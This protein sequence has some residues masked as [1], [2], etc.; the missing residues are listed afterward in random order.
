MKL[1]TCEPHIEEYHFLLDTLY[2]PQAPEA[3]ADVSIVVEFF[4]IFMYFF[5]LSITYACIYLACKYVS[6]LRRCRQ[7]GQAVGKPTDLVRQELTTMPFAGI[8]STSE[9]PVHIGQVGSVTTW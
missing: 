6:S 1:Y 3:V 8:Y 4:Y 7:S 9:L 2:K 5:P